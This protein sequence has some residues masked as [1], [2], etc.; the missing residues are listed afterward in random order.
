MDNRDSE[1]IE[2][3][4]G[5]QSN[6]FQVRSELAGSLRS[7]RIRPDLTDQQESSINGRIISGTAECQISDETGLVTGIIEAP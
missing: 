7:G 2:R 1:Q 6:Y 3:Q 4:L 5:Q